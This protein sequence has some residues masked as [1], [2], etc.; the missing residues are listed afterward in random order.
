MASG[1]D[2][3]RAVVWVAPF[4]VINHALDREACG[5]E[6]QTVVFRAADLR[7]AMTSA[8]LFRMGIKINPR[9]WIAEIVRLEKT[10]IL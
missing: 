8:D 10:G 4:N 7:D 6:Y 9:V 3:W 2:D 1:D 5:P